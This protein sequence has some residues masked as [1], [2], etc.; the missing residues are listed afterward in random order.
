MIHLFGIRHHG[1]GSARSLRRALEQL[2]PDCILIEG[3]P[4]A[5]HLLPLVAHL[6]M[7]PPIA[8]LL[9]VQDNPS[10]AVYYPFAEFSPEYQA[11]K[12]AL[13]NNKTVRFCDLPQTHQLGAEKP[14]LETDQLE[15]EVAADPLGWLAKAA[16]FSDGERYW[17]YLVEQRQTDEDVFTAIREAMTALRQESLVIAPREAQREAF[18][19]S[20][21]R[22]AQKEGFKRIAVVCGAWHTPAL[23]LEQ[24]DAKT[25][26]KILENLPKQKIAATWIP[27]TYGRLARA[28][29]YGAG[30]Q[31]P[32]WYAHL[33][34]YQDLDSSQIVTRW[35]TKVAQLLRA[36]DLPASSASVIEAVRLSEAVAAL[37]GSPMPGLEE[38]Q[39]AARALFAWDSDLPLQLISEKLILAET[40]GSVPAE[41]PTV[42]IV[43]DL[44]AEQK[45]LRFK[46]DAVAKNHEFDLRQPTDLDRSVL[47]HRL[48]LLGIPWGQVQH[49]SGKGTFKEGWKVQWQ[50]EFAVRLIEAAMYGATVQEATTQKILEIVGNAS[51]LPVLTELLDDLLLANLSSATARLL[52]RLEEVA[53]FDSDILNLMDAVPPLARVL[54]YGSVRQFETDLI[55]HVVSSLVLRVCV[56]LPNASAGVSD[57]AAEALYNRILAL[58]A[59]LSTLENPELHSAWREVLGILATQQ[60]HGL[61]AGRCVRLLLEAGLYTPSDTAKRLSYVA[62]I[63]SSPNEVAAWCDGFLRGSGL[64]LVHDDALF[65]VL[66]TWLL[67]L[68][69]EAFTAVLPLMRRTF[70]SFEEGEKRDIGQK[71]K[72]PRQAQI[73]VREV[74]N[75]RAEGVVP[76]IQ[77]MLGISGGN[78]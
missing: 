12:Y 77:K 47:L 40:L 76:L 57:D 29:G 55:G 1:T 2:E 58:Q 73:K 66:D 22:Q 28:S 69:P 75:A 51:S 21:I 30:I 52:A 20:S 17:E 70:S 36:E 72:N 48:R 18:M 54:R 65:G 71:V 4:D 31:S 60:T 59:A 32:G 64:V 16:N 38:L 63:A 37:R 68:S 41:T 33:W 15:N 6:E 27:W 45:R 53:T 78:P 61:I 5:N 56:G 19:R 25:D 44:E 8:L 7:Q 46:P 43:R 49:T 13:T 34:Q 50:P 3:P 11:I 62:G 74:D 24:H 39:E 14:E 10:S 26:A 9:H 23:D 35:M 42:P 67:E